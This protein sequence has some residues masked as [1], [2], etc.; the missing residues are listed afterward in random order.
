MNETL[1]R[2]VKYIDETKKNTKTFVRQWFWC[3]VEVRGVEPLSENPFMQLS[4][5]AVTV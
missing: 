3:V 1:W 2:G 4:P 5:G